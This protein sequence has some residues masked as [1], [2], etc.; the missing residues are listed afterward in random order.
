MSPSL[1]RRELLRTAVGGTVTLALPPLC[2]LAADDAKEAAYQLPKLPYPYDALEPHI[3]A[4][5]MEIH[6]DKHHKAYVDNLNKALE[7]YPRLRGMSVEK[8]LRDIGQVPE[9]VRPAVINNGGGNANHTLFWL[10]MAPKASGSPKGE[11]AR[12]I[13]ASFGSFDKFQAK[14]SD[15]AVKRFGSGWAWLVLDKAKLAVL[16]SANQDSPLMKGQTPILGIDV[17]EHAYYLKYQTR[18]PDYVKAWWH[19]V[20]WENVAERYAQARKSS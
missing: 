11:L 3:D 19:V 18:R 13:D 17:W 20:N 4:R 6:H 1:T 8:L 12:A 9:E 7:G 10:V 15:A 2:R 5:T 16:G 14:L